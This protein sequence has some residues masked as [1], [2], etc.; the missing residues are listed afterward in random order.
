MP[1]I[2]LQTVIAAPPERC[3]DLARSIDFHVVTA[4]TTQERAIAGRTTGLI[5]LG[6][7][8]TWSAKH[9]GIRQ[10]LTVEITLFDQPL[11]FQDVM[12]SGAFAVMRH[13]HY[14]TLAVMRV[15]LHVF[16]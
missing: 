14:F 11:H 13:D 1:T 3:F 9:L 15:L 2:A 10:T 6:E 12:L 7:R 5:E 16:M 8:V 4:G